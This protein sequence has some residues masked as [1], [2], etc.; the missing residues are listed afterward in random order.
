MTKVKLARGKVWH[1]E[2]TGWTIHYNE[3][4]DAPPDVV[5]RAGPR[6]QILV[7]LEEGDDA[8]A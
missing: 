3:S 1:D 2:K 6:L 5:R 7:N 8:G 4:K